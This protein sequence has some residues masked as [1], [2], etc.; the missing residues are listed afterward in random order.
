[1]G[2]QSAY[3]NHLYKN[4]CKIVGKIDTTNSRKE[5]P[6]KFIGLVTECKCNVTLATAKKKI[7]FPNVGGYNV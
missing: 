1:M 6:E 2:H 7:I 5:N 4:L 3:K